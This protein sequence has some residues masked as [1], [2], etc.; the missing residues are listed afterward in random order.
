MTPQTVRPAKTVV[1]LAGKP[2]SDSAAIN[3]VNSVSDVT[4]AAVSRNLIPVAVWASAVRISSVM[5]TWRYMKALRWAGS[6]SRPA[7]RLTL[8][9]GAPHKRD[10]RPR[11]TLAQSPAVLAMPTVR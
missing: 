6:V 8:M 1:C 9:T 4:S 11:T 5:T 2:L 7:M 3:G 10:L